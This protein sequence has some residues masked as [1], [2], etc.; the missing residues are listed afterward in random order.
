MEPQLII[1]ILPKHSLTIVKGME[2]SSLVAIKNMI[3]SI[4]GKGQL[5]SSLNLMWMILSKVTTTKKGMMIMKNNKTTIL[6]IITGAMRIIL[7]IN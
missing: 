7:W 6:V 2:T 5:I 3:P 1:K 4:K